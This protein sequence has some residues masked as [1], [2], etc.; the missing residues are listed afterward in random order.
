[1]TRF[2]GGGNDDDHRK[3]MEDYNSEHE[4]EEALS[5]C[6]LPIKQE[7]NQQSA[8]NS[9]IKSNK[10]ASEGEEFEFGS[11]VGSVLTETEICVA[12]DV[13]FQG[14]I[15]PLRRHSVSSENGFSLKRQDSNPSINP[16][17][18]SSLDRSSSG[19]YT[20]SS[21]SSSSKSHNSISSASTSTTTSGH[22]KPLKN[23]FHS[24]PS[25]KPQ[26]WNSS[27]NSNSIR[28][29]VISGRTGKQSTT[30]GLFRVGLVKTPQ[31]EL[32]DLRLR[33]YKSFNG[34]CSSSGS[35]NKSSSLKNISKGT[36]GNDIGE[37][38]KMQ[39]FYLGFESCKCSTDAVENIVSS[40]TVVIKSSSRKKMS[41]GSELMKE[42]VIMKKEEEVD[43]D[44][45]DG[46][47]EMIKKDKEQGKK[48]KELMNHLRT[49]EWLKQLSVADVPD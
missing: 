16:S 2:N 9:N 3:L 46:E 37:K 22:Y 1:M 30:W 31:I 8:I 4:D 43:D 32:Q 38:K 28:R 15:L 35:S 23:I 39:R 7:V 18:S 25:P 40:Q 26:I 27:N 29:N 14:Q 13:F 42:E 11:C 19:V 49:F 6:D 36:T 33:N 24:H 5:L 47:K 12:D 44:H 45:I 10:A 21:R 41:N 48:Q 17:R 20:T 34:S